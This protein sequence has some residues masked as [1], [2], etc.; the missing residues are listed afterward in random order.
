M[1]LLTLLAAAVINYSIDPAHIFDEESKYEKGIA[2]LLVD[3][4]NVANIVNYDE[5]ITQRLIIEQLDIAPEVIV[6]GSSRAMQIRA[7]DFPENTFFNHSVSGGS[8]EDHMAIYEMYHEKNRLPKHVII[9]ADPWIL[10][11]NNDQSRWQSIKDY[12]YRIT[13]RLNI[14]PADDDTGSS[15]P[16][17]GKY[18]QLISYAYLEESIKY[19]WAILRRGNNTYYPTSETYARSN[20]KLSDGSL[21]YGET[22]RNRNDDDVMLRAVSNARRGIVYSLGNFTE[23]D[24]MT[25]RS[26]DA[27]VQ[28]MKA[29]GVK[30][31]IYLPPYHPSSYEIM[32]NNSAYRYVTESENYFRQLAADR[33]I[34]IIGAY[35]GKKLGCQTDEFTDDMHPTSDCI[36]RFIGN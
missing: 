12:Y 29:D 14:R 23:L 6:L 15:S 34:N 17:Y 5:R 33:M 28:S 2:N 30:V 36:A 19:I 21:V 4:H 7:S 27:F 22:V 16:S 3:G 32:S 11:K 35:D 1:T 20:V 31:T 8:L 13:A 10:N 26:I 24:G 18:L 9:G 25:M